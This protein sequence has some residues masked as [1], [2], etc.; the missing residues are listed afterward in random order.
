MQQAYQFGMVGL[1]V[2][3]QNLLLN[4][5]DNGF[6]VI[7]FDK[8]I[9]KVTALENNASANTVVKGVT[10]LAEMVSALQLPRTIMLLVP[11]GKPVDDVI[12]SLLPI[13]NAGDIIIDGGNSYYLD[14][15]RRVNYLKDKQI[16][17]MGM[18]VSGG[19]EGARKGPALMPGGNVIAYQH[20][21]PIVEAIAA[22]ADGEPCVA[23]MGKGAAGHFVKMVHNGIEYAI[24][25]LI[26]EVYDI[27]KNS[28][29]YS[30]EEMAEIFSNWN[31]GKLKSYLIE[32]TAEILTKK[33]TETDGD[34]IDVI[35]DKA[36]SKGTGKWTSQEALNLGVPIPTI[37]AAVTARS[38][39]A[40]KSE[41]AIAANLYA[42]STSTTE[43]LT[44]TELHDALYAATIL[45]Y[46][47]GLSLIHEAS[48]SLE[49]KVPMKDAVKVW[50]A[51]CIIRSTL[52]GTFYEVFSANQQISNILLDASLAALLQ[53]HIAS[54]RKVAATA[55]NNGL[56]VAALAACINYFDA[57]TNERMPTNMIQAQR[58]FFGS[59]T[60]QRIDKEGTFHTIWS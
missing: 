57:F 8:D 47:Q 51:G 60:Y 19:E 59:H 50:R 5:A 1:G 14:T 28:Q 52:L 58:D 23:Y 12:E 16:H 21:Q 46:A 3:G 18:G 42:K 41:R 20:I 48:N 49:M 45:C 30:N 55:I 33:Y 44:V 25:Q 6:N 37:D 13:I 32:I 4:I 39:S 22:K 40:Y 56:S 9:A 7:G 36:G 2:M 31:Q 10:T 29:G 54:L 38:I 17:F 35:L 34:V 15:L 43:K 26:T 53:P 24:M 11:A 27:L